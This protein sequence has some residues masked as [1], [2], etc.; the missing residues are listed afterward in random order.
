MAERR[1]SK[2]SQPNNLTVIKYVS[3]NSTV[4][5]HRT[6]LGE[7][8]RQVSEPTSTYGT[9]QAATAGPAGV[10]RQ[11]AQSVCMVGRRPAARRSRRRGEI[12]DRKCADLVL[13]AGTHLDPNGL[14]NRILAVSHN[15]RRTT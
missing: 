13:L 7:A 8:K 11:A 6:T 12:T 9:V 3:R 1:R 10:H 2:P 15:G 5:E 4:N 14:E